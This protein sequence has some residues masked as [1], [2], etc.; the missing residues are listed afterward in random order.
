MKRSTRP[1]ADTRP[2]PAT[3][4]ALPTAER[5]E[6]QRQGAKAAARGDGRSGNPMDEASNLP[7]TTG[8]CADLWQERK[9]AWQSGHEA[10]SKTDDGTATRSGADRTRDEH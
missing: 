8:E 7:T 1:H 5:A 6:L 3:E 4:R 10:Q 2:R 9:E